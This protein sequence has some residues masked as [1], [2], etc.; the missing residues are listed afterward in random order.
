MEI[1]SD[2]KNK[3]LFPSFSHLTFKESDTVYLMGLE[4]HFVLEASTTK[5]KHW[6]QTSTTGLIKGSN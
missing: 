2:D 6:I 1:E 4:G 5:I 3:S